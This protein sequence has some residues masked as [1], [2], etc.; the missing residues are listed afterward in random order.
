MESIIRDKILTYLLNHDCLSD[1]QH[2]FVPGRNRISQLLQCL[3]DWTRTIEEKKSFDIIYTNFSKAFDSVAHQRLILKLEMIGITGDVLGWIKSFL[4]GRT[5]CVKV[6]GVKSQ[7]KS[8][9]S[10]VPQ[11]SVLGPLLFLI[12][13]NDIPGEVKS[14]TCKLF[15]DAARIVK[16]RMVTP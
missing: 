8:V 3:E 5:Q 15:A 4:N 9:V 2:G 1:E 14:N 12:F 16:Q 6:D 11:G 13:I 10:G 7:W